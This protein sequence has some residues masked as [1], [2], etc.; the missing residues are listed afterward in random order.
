MMARTLKNELTWKG[1]K[2]FKPVKK[3]WTRE[4]CFTRKPKTARSEG[5]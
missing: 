5:K 4:G 3:R 1:Q 2:M